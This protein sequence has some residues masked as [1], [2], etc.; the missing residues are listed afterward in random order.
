MPRHPGASFLQL[1]AG[2]GRH[3]AAL[4]PGLSASVCSHLLWLLKNRTGTMS[5]ATSNTHLVDSSINQIAQPVSTSIANV[6][7]MK[8]LYCKS[9]HP[10]SS[11][12][13]CTIFRF[14][15]IHFIC[16][17]TGINDK[18]LSTRLYRNLCCEKFQIRAF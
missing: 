10:L 5:S 11:Q 3:C 17:G 1:A 2:P 12:S 7:F 18:L 13:R 15:A 4:Q 16:H 14:R 9:C 8:I 6:A